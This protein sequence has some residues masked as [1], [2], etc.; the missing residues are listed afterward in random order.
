[1]DPRDGR[2]QGR[3]DEELFLRRDDAPETPVV[4]PLRIQKRESA[5][6]SPPPRTDSAGSAHHQPV[7]SRPPPMPA[8]PAP[9]TNATQ[10]QLPYPDDDRPPH[11]QTLSSARYASLTDAETKAKLQDLKHIEDH[12]AP[13]SSSTGP[14]PSS[15][16][17]RAR[18]DAH[19][20]NRPSVAGYGGPGRGPD[21]SIQPSRLAERRGTAPKPLPDSPGPET[22]DKEGLFQRA[23]QRQASTD[24]NPFPDYHQQY[25]PPPQ[26][27]GGPK[28]PE[29]ALKIPNPAG[30]NRLSSTAS[31]STTKAQRGSP[32]PPETP[33][34]PPPSGGIEAR[35]AAAGIAGPSTLTSL[36]AQTAQNAA[37]A[38][39]NQVYANQQP[40]QNIASPAPSQQP[41]RRPWTP[42]EQPGSQP[43]GPPTVY[44]GMNQVGPSSSPPQAPL[45]QVPGHVPTST[46]SPPP[47]NGQAGNSLAHDMGR[48][49]MNEEPPPA[50]SSIQHPPATS[51]AG[52]PNEKQRPQ[53]TPAPAPQ[54]PGVMSDPN[55]Q[56]HPA[57]AND[58]RSPQTGPSSSQPLSSP[59]RRPRAISHR[60]LSRYNM[61]ARLVQHQQHRVLVPRRLLRSPRDGSHI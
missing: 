39:R 52:F 7:F 2:K 16:A 45:P 27:P 26:A 35:F 10:T 42:T 1:M 51:S 5:T 46:G 25:W 60:N 6:K 43:H 24:P 4:G 53:G 41:P 38:Q 15:P 11:H 55:L 32:P 33:I 47:T 59:Q 17:S 29:P 30:I 8:F 54:Q 13:S 19:D 34:I 58:L 9:P 49:N 44:Q 3:P 23:P 22:P 12:P 36:Q 56:Q 18:F 20:P 50:Y 31:T 61:R 37:A 28:S 48:M 21:G 14:S 57:F 40:R